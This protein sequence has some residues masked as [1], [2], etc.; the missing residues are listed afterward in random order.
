MRKVFLAGLLCCALILSACPSSSQQPGSEDTGAAESTC[1]EI[2]SAWRA[3]EGLPYVWGGS[4]PADG[5]LDCSGAIYFVQKQIGK[6][7]PRTTSKRYFLFASGAERHW[8][9]AQCGDWVWWTLQAHRPYGHIGMHV[10]QP[11]VWQSGSSTGPAGI[12]LSEGG[13]WDG[14]FEASKSLGDD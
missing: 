2:A 1:A 9:E 12:R 5:G 14:I 8:R 10:E 13:Y 4:T 7:V 3:I 11:V 6:P